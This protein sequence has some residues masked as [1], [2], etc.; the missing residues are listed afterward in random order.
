MFLWYVSQQI[1]WNFPA[2]LSIFGISMGTCPQFQAFHG[3]LEFSC[4][5]KILCLKSFGNSWG[6]SW[7]HSPYGNNNLVPIHLWCRET[8][9]KYE[10]VCKYFVP[11]CLKILFFVLTFLKMHV[12]SKNDYF[13]VTKINTSSQILPS[14]IWNSF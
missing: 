5:P 2:K 13:L 7:A 6:T 3:F 8:I 14:C 1:F 9:L 4:F 11:Y 10:K 12:N